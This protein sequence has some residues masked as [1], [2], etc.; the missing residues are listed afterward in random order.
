MKS[1]QRTRVIDWIVS[2]ACLLV[3]LFFILVGVYS[4]FHGTTPESELVEKTG[5]ATDATISSVL[6][7]SGR[8]TY[9]MWFSVDGYRVVYASDQNGYNRLLSA[10]RDGTPLTIRIST[11]RETI[12][13]RNGWVPLYSLSIG[14]DVLLTYRDTVMK[15]YRGSNA[16]FIVGGVL[17]AIA[18]FGL[19]TCI[20]NRKIPHQ[21]P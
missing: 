10:V 1:P 7:R 13:P 16:A 17:S 4:H 12:F 21:F 3:A 6:D 14:T 19:F 15:S 11:L 18:L 9:Y 8:T 20:R 2:T 5:S